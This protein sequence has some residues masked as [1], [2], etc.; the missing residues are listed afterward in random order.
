MVWIE[1]KMGIDKLNHAL[2]QKFLYLSDAR[3]RTVILSSLMQMGN[4][5]GC[6]LCCTMLVAQNQSVIDNAKSLGAMMMLLN[7]DNSI[8]DYFLHSNKRIIVYT[9]SY[10]VQIWC[11]DKKNHPL[12]TFYY[13]V[14]IILFFGF[15]LSSF[16]WLV[17]SVDY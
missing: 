15:F 4:A 16:I 9:R 11:Y 6:L 7:I 13:T 5:I 14:E 1:Y 2:Y 8:G 10:L 17:K 3:R 12:L